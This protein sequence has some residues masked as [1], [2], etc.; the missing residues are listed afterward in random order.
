MFHGYHDVR[1]PLLCCR[2]TSAS[3][4]YKSQRKEAP[5]E[6]RGREKHRKKKNEKEGEL[7][8]IGRKKQRV[9]N[10]LKRTK[11]EIDRGRA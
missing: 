11:R 10:L 8:S 1:R 6:D 4:G 3:S 5:R 2:K 9:G 7:G